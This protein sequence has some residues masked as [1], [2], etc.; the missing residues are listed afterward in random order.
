LVFLAGAVSAQELIVDSTFDAFSR[1]ARVHIV[2][3]TMPS[4]L[5]GLRLYVAAKV[6]IAPSTDAYLPYTATCEA[7]VGFEQ[8]EPGHYWD[9]PH[10]P[11]ELLTRRPSGKVVPA[12]ASS[13]E[14]ATSRPSRARPGDAAFRLTPQRQAAVGITAQLYR[15]TRTAYLL[16][17]P[18]EF[19][20]AA[21]A[22]IVRADSALA[23]A[24]KA[25]R[26]K[27]VCR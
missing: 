12:L 20:D 14:T 11:I 6:V 13:P 7:W 23:V 26:V 24:T 17:F 25:N 22:V 15:D 19:F 2:S 21:K 10:V 5:P 27:E 9:T 16:E 1:T 3:R 8:E 4:D 18:A